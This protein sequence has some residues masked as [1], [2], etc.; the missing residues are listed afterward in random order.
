MDQDNIGALNQR[1]REVFQR[2]VDEYLETGE[3]IGSRTISRRLETALSPATVRNVMADLEEFGLVYSPHTSAGRLPTEAG[4]RLFVDGLLEFGADLSKDEQANIDTQC[5]AAGRSFV[6]VQE[7]ASSA[8]AGLSHCAGLVMS[9][10]VDTGLKHVEFVPLNREQALVV[11]VTASGQVENRVIDLPA[12]MPMSVLTQATNYLNSRLGGRSLEEV[13]ARVSRELE[14]DQAQLDALTGR[15]VEDGLAIWA[16]GIKGGSLI[17][18]GQAKLLDDVTA[19]EDLERIR[20]L[21]EVLEQKEEMV[22]L[23]G[24]TV[25]ADGVRIFIGAENNLFEHTGCAMIIA[26]YGDADR[27]VVGAIGVVGPTRMNYARI[28]PM[29]DYTSRLMSRILGNG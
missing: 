10:K 21:F 8:L 29:V 12:G 4:L 15:V 25:S 1:S 6:E 13:Q 23:L 14:E 17:V 16:G 11:M 20:S 2:V 5:A 7:E 26:P 28:I 24:D 27:R 9:P 3:P 18:R 19:V 22:R